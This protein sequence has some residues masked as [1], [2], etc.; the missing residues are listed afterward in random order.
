MTQKTVWSLLAFCL[1]IS[2]FKSRVAV[3]ATDRQNVETKN[4]QAVSA[5]Q[6]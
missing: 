5:S 6:G 2:S 1:V 4:Q 3:E